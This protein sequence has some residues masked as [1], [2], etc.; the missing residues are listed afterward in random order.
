MTFTKDSSAKRNSQNLLMAENGILSS[1]FCKSS[2]KIG[3][4]FHSIKL[5]KGWAHKFEGSVVSN[6]KL[7]KVPSSM[8]RNFYY[9]L[10]SFSLS[11][12][13]KALFCFFI[14]HYINVNVHNFLK[15]GFLKQFNFD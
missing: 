3:W 2:A 11:N 7:L 14:L 15:S 10:F 4:R 12:D 13:N 1:Y 9:V 6:I 5:L 8:K